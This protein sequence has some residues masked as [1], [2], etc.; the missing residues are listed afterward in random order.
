MRPTGTHGYPGRTWDDIDEDGKL[1]DF[2]D[3]NKVTIQVPGDNPIRYLIDNGYLARPVF[4]TLLAKPGLAI[5]DGDLAR[6]ASSLDIPDD[7]L[8]N[9]SMT[10]Q[11]VAAALEAIEDLL[12]RAHTRVLVFA[13]SVELAMC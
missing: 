11:Y 13:A 12:S 10:D 2:Y 7:V 8:S 6:I 9:L 1:A 4:R 3:H 5:D